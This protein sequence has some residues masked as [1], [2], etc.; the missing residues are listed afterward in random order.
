M[1]AGCKRLKSKFVQQ[2][3]FHIEIFT[4]KAAVGTCS[5]PE[6][7]GSTGI[8]A[9]CNFLYMTPYWSAGV[10]TLKYLKKREKKKHILMYAW[11]QTSPMGHNRLKS[12]TMMSHLEYQWKKWIKLP[13]FLILGQ[14][15]NTRVQM[16]YFSLLPQM[17]PSAIKEQLYDQF[18]LFF[19]IIYAFE[20][21]HGHFVPFLFFESWLLTF[22]EW[23]EKTWEHLGR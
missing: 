12:F 4:S 14:F 22:F 9:S 1:K 2:W 20:Q 23:L 10:I 16:S 5:S 13:S 19:S 8:P 3:S 7:W 21:L 11:H 17:P 18:I 6:F 15:W